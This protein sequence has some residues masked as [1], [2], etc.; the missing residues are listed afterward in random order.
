VD[1]QMVTAAGLLAV[2][3]PP[4]TAP[5]RDREPPACTVIEPLILAPGPA[6]KI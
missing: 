2:I 5:V 3:P 4:T 1:P 6:Q